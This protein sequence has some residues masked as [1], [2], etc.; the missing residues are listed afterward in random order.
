MRH[1]ENRLDKLEKENGMDLPEIEIVRVIITPDNS[2]PPVKI[3][4]GPDGNYHLNSET[5]LCG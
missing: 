1:L 5:D 4:R 3:K 2:E